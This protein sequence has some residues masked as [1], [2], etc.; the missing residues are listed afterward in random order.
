MGTENGID[1]LENHKRDT[2]SQKKYLTGTFITGVYEDKIDDDVFWIGAFYKGLV[3]LKNGHPVFYTKKDGFPTKFI[4]QILEDDYGNL[5]MSSDNGVVKVSKRILNEFAEGDVDKINCTFYGIP[6]GMNTN[7]CSFGTRNSIIKT[8]SGE[9]WFSTLK[10]IAVVHP[11]KI[12][13]N[14]NP[15]PII[16]KKVLFNYEKK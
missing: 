15:P 10:G 13:I 8:Q 4:Y 6:D 14:K 9:F 2:L 1:I 7:Q 3:R 11:G 16:I 5:W 12:K